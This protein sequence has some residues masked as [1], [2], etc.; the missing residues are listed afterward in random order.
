[1]S[2]LTAVV[3]RLQSKSQP[4]GADPSESFSAVLREEMRV[5]Q[6]AF[7]LKINKAAADHA[8]KVAELNKQTRALQEAL[9]E[10]RRN[11]AALAD[12]LR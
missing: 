4:A 3:E 8:A 9:T 5:M 12:K 2:K 10:E 11:S 6:S 1:M 7:T